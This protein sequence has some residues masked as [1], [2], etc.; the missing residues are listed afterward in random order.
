MREAFEA[1]LGRA[2]LALSLSLGPEGSSG[3]CGLEE[4]LILGFRVRG[5]GFRVW[6]LG[7]RV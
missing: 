5:L 3:V 7:F 1:E 2:A 4:P 6:G